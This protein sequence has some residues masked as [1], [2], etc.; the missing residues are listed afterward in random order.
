MEEM[1]K[2]NLDL[3]EDI[4]ASDIKSEAALRI[5]ATS[6]S[7]F[8]YLDPN[9]GIIILK[10][11]G[12]TQGQ[13]SVELF[14]PVFDFISTN[15]INNSAIEVHI[16]I[17]EYG[18]N[19]SFLKSLVDLFRILGNLYKNNVNVICYWYFDELD[20]DILQL[21]EDFESQTR[22]PIVFVE[23]PN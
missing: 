9:E 20:E 17:N 16:M 4:I 8:I 10:G 15:F 21:G 22:V 13:G 3:I 12:R 19:T 5:E 2:K 1:H 23:V 11:A 6:T 18:C 14:K 7:P